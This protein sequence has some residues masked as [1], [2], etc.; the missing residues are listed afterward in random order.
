MSIE[1]Q[2][3]GVSPCTGLPYA[4]SPQLVCHSQFGIRASS[5]YVPVR[6]TNVV[7]G[8]RSPEGLGPASPAGLG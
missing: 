2:E 1:S 4:D 7:M 3:Y 5:P 6:H 8:V